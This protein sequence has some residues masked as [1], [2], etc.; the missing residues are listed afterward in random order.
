MSIK[1]KKVALLKSLRPKIDSIL[2]QSAES[3][4]KL[5]LN[6]P[7]LGSEE[8]LAALGC[9]LDQ[10]L[11]MGPKVQAFE[12]QFA[13]YVGKKHA[14][15]VNSGSSANL[16]MI[17][18]LRNPMASPKW[19]LSPGDEIIV[20]AV[21]W[22]TT[23]TPVINAGF[24]PVLVDAD[25]KTL[26]MDFKA[27]REAIGPKTKA[28]FVAHILGNSAD[29]KA[30]GQLAKERNLIL[31]EDSCESL[32]TKFQSKMTGTFGL[33]GSYSFYFSHHITTIEGGM[34]VTDED[35]YAELLRALR[36]HGWTRHLLNREA[37]EAQHDQLDSR[38]L[39]INT[40]FNVRATDLQAAIGIEQLKKL[41]GFNR[42]RISIAAKLKK[43]LSEFA[44]ELDF[45]EPTHS[46]EHTWFGFPFLLKGDWSRRRAEFVARLNELKIENRPVVAGNLAG[47]PFL[48]HFPHRV[49][50]PLPGAE[51][52]MASGVYVGS[53]PSTTIDQIRYLK[54]ALALIFKDKKWRGSINGKK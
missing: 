23:I 54:K 5:P 28:I 21:T 11:T 39:F 43:E 3:P 33:A 6:A 47:Q 16:L 49:S 29:M 42:H 44:N 9:F 30:L 40:G 35:D 32:G 4:F 50:G 15:M 46:T 51:R 27:V 45:I 14:L 26:C 17:E 38:F 13:K 1:K 10:Q 8:V 25:P 37:V 52:I 53:H 7:T 18:A 12:K 48:K 2:L 19:R 31:L 20:P 36:A 41:K 22:S 24:V 34:I